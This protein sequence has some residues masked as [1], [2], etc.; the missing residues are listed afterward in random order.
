VVTEISRVT[1]ESQSLSMRVESLA[2]KVDFNERRVRGIEGAMHQARPVGRREEPR[3]E[4]VRRELPESPPAQQVV[5]APAPEVVVAVEPAP[6]GQVPP[7]EGTRR[8]RRRRRGRRGTAVPGEAVAGVAD[9]AALDVDELGEGSDE[10]EGS[11]AIAEPDLPPEGADFPSELPSEGIGLRP[12]TTALPAEG[13]D[14]FWP[15]DGSHEVVAEQ[16][17]VVVAEAEAP[18]PELVVFESE[19]E[20]QPGPPERQEAQPPEL[21]ADDLAAPALPERRDLEPTD[22]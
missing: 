10:D 11:P 9:A 7:S 15:E 20:K 22:R 21:P 16:T 5:V 6:P 17:I 4:D 1:L 13:V 14:R 18:P 2:G 19:M 3:R 8:R 12:E